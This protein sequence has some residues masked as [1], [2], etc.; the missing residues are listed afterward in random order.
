MLRLAAR[1]AAPLRSAARP[2]MLGTVATVDKDLGRTPERTAELERL[3]E[4]HNGFLF[5]E[6][7]RAPPVVFTSKL[8]FSRLPT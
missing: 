8:P 4:E 1:A 6:V 5:G 2:R 3:A 7:V